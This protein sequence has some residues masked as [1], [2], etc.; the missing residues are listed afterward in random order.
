[1]SEKTPHAQRDFF[2]HLGGFITLYWSMIA[3]LVVLFQ[4]VNLQFP[5]LLSYSDPAHGAL[6]FG[7]SSL[8]IT[9][10]A[11]VGVMVFLRKQNVTRPKFPIHFTLFV[12]A[13]TNIVNVVSL[14]YRLTGGDIT[15]RFLLKVLSVFVVTGGVFAFERWQLR[16]D[17]D[18]MASHVKI[19]IGLAYVLV[20]ASVVSGFV[21]IGSPVSRRG[22]ETDLRRVSDL[23]NLQWMIGGYV[24]RTGDLP[25]TIADLGYVNPDPAGLPYVYNVTGSDTFELCATFSRESSKDQNT[26]LYGSPVAPF[27]QDFSHGSGYTCF[28]R[29]L[30]DLEVIMGTKF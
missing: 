25:E 26:A 18:T 6:R 22:L 12:T 21:M 23:Q 1:M 2:L 5:D 20:L 8:I 27:G 7:L 3:L 19:W 24:D 4:L 29:S 30:N 17:A 15:S 28:T 16:R 9:F 13:L 11:F 14:V 10:P